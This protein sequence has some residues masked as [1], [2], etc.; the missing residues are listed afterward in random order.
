M[1]S[2]GCVQF[3]ILSTCNLP[4]SFDLLR[5][6]VKVRSWCVVLQNFVKLYN[7]S[8]KVEE[9]AGLFLTFCELTYM[10]LNNC[11]KQ[12]GVVTSSKKEEGGGLN[13]TSLS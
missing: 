13:L 11:T 4:F 2:S 9:N 6:E 10:P 5:K 8:C 12:K 1:V 7:K 3:Q